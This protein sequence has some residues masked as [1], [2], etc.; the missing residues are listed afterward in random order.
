MIVYYTEV[1]LIWLVRQ[2]CEEVVRRSSCGSEAAWW[3][4]AEERRLIVRLKKP[5]VDRTDWMFP[6]DSHFASRYGNFI[7]AMRQ[8]VETRSG[9]VRVEG[10]TRGD[11]FVYPNMIDEE[12][13]PWHGI[14]DDA[15]IAVGTANQNGEIT[16]ERWPVIRHGMFFRIEYDFRS[17]S[18]IS[19]AVQDLEAIW[20]RPIASRTANLLNLEKQLRR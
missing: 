15:T 18:G 2:G 17:Y 7:V 12:G 14:F 6:A 4:L 10:T 5:D 3:G 8:V 11:T 20:V 9:F 16:V 1:I 13:S 19:E